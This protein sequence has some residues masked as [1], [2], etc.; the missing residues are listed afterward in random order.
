MIQVQIAKRSSIRIT[1]IILFSL[2]FSFAYGAEQDLRLI[3]ER[4]TFRQAHLY[5]I[6]FRDRVSA[7]ESLAQLQAVP[8]DQLF[9]VFEETAKAK[10]IDLGS[11]KYGGDLGDMDN[12]LIP[13]EFISAI[14]ALPPPSLSGVIQTKFGW[15]IIYIQSASEEPVKN[16]CEKLLNEGIKHAGP[17]DEGA[18]KLTRMSYTKGANLYPAI[19]DVIGTDWTSPLTDPDG[20]LYYFRVESRKNKKSVVVTQHIEYKYA[21]LYEHG[22]MRSSRENFIVDCEASLITSD[23]HPANYELRGGAGRIVYKLPPSDTPV[24]VAPQGDFLM[25]LY[26]MA[27]SAR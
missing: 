19:L 20:N 11:A 21:K 6:M 4:D 13:S 5:H 3:D 25:R 10:S 17:D 22:C 12:R 16:I 26:K 8:I 1:V 27:C 15:H 24:S 7:E 14:F 23:A 2:F 18:I 9:A